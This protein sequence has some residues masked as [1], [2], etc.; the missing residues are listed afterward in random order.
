MT[1]AS[2]TQHSTTFDFA[3]AMYGPWEVEELG[4]FSFDAKY[5]NSWWIHS[6]AESVLER[7]AEESQRAESSNVTYIAGLYYHMPPW[8][9]LEFNYTRL[10]RYSG[11]VDRFTP[12]PVD[13]VW[14]REL[15]HEPAIAVAN[16]SLYYPI[17]GLVWDIE[18]YNNDVTEREDYSYDLPAIQAFANASG[19][20][21][22]KIPANGGY[23][24]LRQVDMLEDYHEWIYQEVF[25]MARETE[26]AVHSINPGFAL[27]LLGT[28]HSW[29][30]WAILQGF[31]SSTAPVTSWCEYTYGGYRTIGDEGVAH[32]QE[33]WEEHDLNGRFVPGVRPS[34]EFGKFMWDLGMAARH[35]GVYWIYQHNGDPFSKISRETYT[36]MYQ[37]YDEFVFHNGSDVYPLAG[38]EMLPG[39]GALPFGGLDGRVSLLLYTID[40]S[41]PLGFDLVTGA[42]EVTYVGKNLTKK[43]IEVDSGDLSLGADD[44]PCFV[45]GLNAGDLAPTEAL[46]YIN[47]LGFLLELYS[48]LDLVQ[49]EYADGLLEQSISLYNEGRFLDVREAIL[50]YR[51][52]TYQHTFDVLMPLVEAGFRNPGESPYPVD[53]LRD[54][55]LAERRYKRVDSDEVKESEYLPGSLLTV[56]RGEL[57][58]VEGLVRMVEHVCEGPKLVAVLSII[59][60]IGLWNCAGCFYSGKKL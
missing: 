3:T 29:H 56:R 24:W 21:V 17:W 26:R 18:L 4:N 33:L 46:A 31:N 41:V 10:V 5:R 45:Y 9:R 37:I 27:G 38:F 59:L 55:Y 6:G 20:S 60:V 36:R 52:L 39:T 32:F 48:T 19:I 40:E 7:F 30:H 16:L 50:E 2:G 49:P 1:S 47:E 11:E 42:D 53:I 35:T 14:W 23:N 54:I 12:S 34:H 13:E 22:P 25:S 44:L 58:L 51:N 57:L 15:M 28:V 8:D 43:R